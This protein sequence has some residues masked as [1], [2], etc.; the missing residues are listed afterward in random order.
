MARAELGVRYQN[1]D[2]F[3]GLSLDAGLRVGYA[4]EQNLYRGFDVRSLDKTAEVTDEPYI[5]LVLRG[6]F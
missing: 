5:A 6:T 2:V 3:K 4:C 1:S